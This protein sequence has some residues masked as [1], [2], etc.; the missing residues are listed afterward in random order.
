M[1]RWIARAAA[2]ALLCAL[3]G[4][5]GQRIAV[6]THDAGALATLPAGWHFERAPLAAAPGIGSALAAND[7]ALRAALANALAARGYRQAAEGEPGALLLDYGVIDRLSP[8]A[9]R[10]DSPGDY[11]RSWREP[12]ISQ[13]G[14]GAMDHAVA[15]AA[16]GRELRLTVLLRG[17]DTRALLWE[18]SATR[19]M[20]ADAAPSRVLE[21]MARDLAARLP[22]R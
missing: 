10:L 8:N 21:G 2:L 1:K 22:R 5:A 4:C 20:A 18:A 9:K 15:D 17:A 6:R 14:T 13:D 12:G 3:A 7:S 16:F 19:V 11:Q